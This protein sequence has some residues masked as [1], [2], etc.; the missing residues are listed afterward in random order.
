MV[1]GAQD[2]GSD[3]FHFETFQPSEADVAANRAY[4]ERFDG[5]QELVGGRP[6]I[7]DDDRRAASLISNEANDLIVDFEVGGAAEYKRKYIHPERPPGDS[8]VTIG[9]GYDLG[10]C[11]KDDFASDWRDHVSAEDFT[12]LARAVGLTRDRAA[13][14]LPSV[15]GLVI[16]WVSALQVYQLVDMPSF[17]GQTR[18]AFPGSDKLHPHCFGALVSLVFNRGASLA[19]DRRSEMYQIQRAIGAGQ[20]EKVPH[21]FRQM[22]RLWPATPGLVRRRKAEAALFERGLIAAE[23]ERRLGP[24]ITV[25]AA[26]GSA[27]S[28]QESVQSDQAARHDGDARGLSD[29]DYADIPAAEPGHGPL[30]SVRPE[31]AGV[32]WI[33]DDTLSTD[34]RHLLAD[35]R[36]RVNEMS[37]LFTAADL[38]LLIRANQFAPLDQHKR[39]IFGLRGATLAF[40]ASSNGDRT[41][42]VNRQSLRLKACRPDHQHFRCVMGV[43]NTETR[44]LSGFMASTVPNR[45]AVQKCMAT[46]KNG[47]LLATGCYEYRVGS[48]HGGKYQG[49]LRQSEP[50][51]VLRSRE[52]LVYDVAD[53]WDI[54][55]NPDNWPVDNIHP[56]FADGSYR[57]AEFSSFGCQVIRGA[58]PDGGYT[59]E[60]AKFRRALGLAEPPSTSEDGRR[61]SYVLLTGDEAAISA[62]LRDQNRSGDHDAVLSSLARLRQGSRGAM[63][64][65]LQAALKLRV[66][67]ALTAVVKKVL[68]D[69]Q[70]QFDHKLAGDGIY[71]P[72]LDT[73]LA[74]GVFAPPEIAANGPAP[75]MAGTQVA[76]LKE[77]SNGG[78]GSGNTFESV[79]YDLGRRSTFAQA[80]PALLTVQVLPQYESVTQESWNGMVQQGRKVLARA[81]LMLHDVLC[82]DDDADKGDRNKVRSALAQSFG[83]GREQVI[84]TLSRIITGTLMIPGLVSTPIAEVLYDRLAGAMGGSAGAG[85]DAQMSTVCIAWRRNLQAGQQ[86]TPSGERRALAAAPLPADPPRAIS[87]APPM[88]AAQSVPA[89][90]EGGRGRSL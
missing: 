49:C 63:V 44:L 65:R 75:Y 43:Y 9:I 4:R 8:G 39:I 21:L 81:E 52:N 61:F 74:L 71:S 37:F 45:G 22:T 62:M 55:V 67:G 42:Q 29:A 18:R 53:T 2:E 51:A 57:S 34:Y 73:Q 14:F 50:M 78:G 19:G 46:G 13:A 25:A 64:E 87:A 32:H 79:F 30:E 80:N 23:N 54:A 47:N 26:N 11:D 88:A 84:G 56:A 5:L 16:P 60:F 28:V 76:S 83:G 66:D 33:D 82:G 72:Q 1:A 68:I 3:D 15:K 86:A 38:E 6:K 27:K 31:W 58:C 35:D 10:Y 20:P 41:A 36:R 70:R 7:S 17:A 69:V 12:A 77:A 40:D 59:D 24:P 89:A 48:H 90:P 85:L